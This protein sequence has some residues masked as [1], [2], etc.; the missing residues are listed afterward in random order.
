MTIT[1]L[2]P[3]KKL[4]E[5]TGTSVSAPG[6]EGRFQ[7]LRN[8]APLVSALGTG[9]VVIERADGKRISFDIE[10]GFAE[11]HRNE[12]NLLVQGTSNYRE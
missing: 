5:G 7:I 9:G 3:D 4:F 10:R 2:T 1:V 6:V 8:H 12:V 11:V